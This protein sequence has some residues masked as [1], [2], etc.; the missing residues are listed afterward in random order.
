[1]ADTLAPGVRFPKPDKAWVASA[2]VLLAVALFDRSEVWPTVTFSAGA[3]WHTAPFV[4]FAVATIAYVK[5]AGAE[6][7][8]S[9]LFEGRETRMI[10]AAA[11]L[12]GLSPFCSCEV[13]PFIA[14]SLA[15]GAPLSAVMAFWL[16]SPLM[17]PAMF[18]VTS[19]TLGLDFALGKTVAAVGI[20]LLGGAVTMALKGSPVFADP[21][22]AAPQTG[23]GC[24]CS[25]KKTFS[26]KPAWRF[27]QEPARRETF[28]DEAL[29]NL[30][31]LLKWLLLAYLI[32]AVMLRY[33]PAETIA[34]L[35][36]GDGIWPIFLGAM[37][38]APAYLNGYAAVPLVDALLAQGMAPGA[39][40]SF[41]VAGGVSCIPAAIAV[42]AL[43]KPRVFAAYMGFAV[44][45][46]LAAGLA[47]GAL[48]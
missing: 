34:S 26:G 44:A 7:L 35:L 38:G 1:M 16:A 28:R 41:V 47:W 13:I 32:E 24:C 18:L 21:L 6:T 25:A 23:G 9:R 31:F 19:G 2:L 42:W 36:G 8:L 10:V 3:L 15:V 43:V 46:S 22:R 12:G 30:M 40:M 37:V 29:G 17:D 14:A 5:A 20:G 39:A 27:W 45:G 11:L 4:L 48:A 33:I